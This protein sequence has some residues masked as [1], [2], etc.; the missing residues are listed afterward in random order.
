M[1]AQSNTAQQNGPILVIE[2]EPSV[3]WFVRTALE[4][5]GYSVL[6]ASTGAE[7]LELL[8]DGE[9]SGVVSDMRTPGGVDGS[10]V[11]DWLCVNRPELKDRL[12]FITGDI[13]SADT[14][15]A[16]QRTGVPHLEK[17]F[18]VRQ[19]LD[20]IERIMGKSQ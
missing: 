13:A 9:C 3:L 18:L 1:V 2:D 20:V 8:R 12:I 10:D 15:E 17:P 11:H 14:A 6:T 7:A 19:L 4:R 5:N 16:L